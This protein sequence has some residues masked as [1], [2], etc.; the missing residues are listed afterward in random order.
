[1]K[2][3]INLRLLIEYLQE[4][5]NRRD[6]LRLKAAMGDEKAKKELIDYFKGL[7]LPSGA[8][9]YAFQKEKPGTI[10]D[11]YRAYQILKELKNGDKKNQVIENI[12]GFLKQS[13]HKDGSW[14]EKDQVLEIPDLPF[15]MDPRKKE[16]KILTT[17]YAILIMVI[18]LPS[19]LHTTKGLDF[20]QEHQRNDGTFPGFPHTTWIAG[21]AFLGYYGKSHH[22]GQRMVRVIDGLIKKDHP[23]S[24]L[25]W[26]ASSLIFAG[27]TPHSLTI[28]SRVL[29]KL[30]KMQQANGLWTAEDQDIELETAVNCLITLDMGEQINLTGEDSS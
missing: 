28:L 29:D 9:P 24:V 22:M 23:G 19:S 5:A 17:A 18:E 2:K 11:T 27:Y 26:I 4:N 14:D 21:A 10:I 6:I 20:L 15:W 16:V 25:Q 13:Q 3:T 7:Q 12:V 30:K 1:M 8:F